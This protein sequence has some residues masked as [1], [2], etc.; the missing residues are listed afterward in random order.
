MNK[1]K[2]VIAED[3]PLA[4][5][6]LLEQLLPYPD[7]EVVGVAKHGQEA[8][9]LAARHLPQVVLLDIQMPEKTGLQAAQD[10]L[11]LA[12]NQ[13][14]YFPQ[15]VFIT[16]YDQYALDAFEQQAIDYILKPFTA[17]RLDKMIRRVRQYVHAGP[18]PPDLTTWTNQYLPALQALMN[19]TYPDVL[20]IK[21]GTRIHVVKVSEITHIE[22]EGNY[23]R[24]CTPGARYLMT[25]TLTNLQLKLN[26]HQ[27]IRIHRSTI[28]NKQ[29]IKEIRTHFNGD[30]TVIL[31]NQI[32]LRMSRSF[33]H[34][35]KL[36]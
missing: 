1:I 4:A 17:D 14:D 32:N 24:V 6:F 28:V 35:L 2:V 33:K 29:Y 36:D 15:V 13:P 7:L 5:E 9:E 20:T 26:P 34:Q 19:Q 27:F 8:V 11:H 16:A 23:M 22:A 3:E 12:A 18:R 21:D 25:E 10:I 30:A 31:S